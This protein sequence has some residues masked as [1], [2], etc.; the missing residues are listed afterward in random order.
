[1]V[2]SVVLFAGNVQ[3]SEMYVDDL[4]CLKETDFIASSIPLGST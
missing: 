1:M 2:Y 4:E 3:H